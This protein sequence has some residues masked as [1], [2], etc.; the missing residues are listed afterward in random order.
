VA[1][2]RGIIAMD[3]SIRQKQLKDLSITNNTDKLHVSHIIF[4]IMENYKTPMEKILFIKYKKWLHS[5]SIIPD[6]IIKEFKTDLIKLRKW[7]SQNIIRKI[8]M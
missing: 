2:I 1:R 3:I 8:T 4:K 7:K 5:D 6:D